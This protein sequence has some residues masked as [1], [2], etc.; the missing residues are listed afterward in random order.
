[1]QDVPGQWDLLVMIEAKWVRY[2][3]PNWKKAMLD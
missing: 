3:W 1:M 2:G